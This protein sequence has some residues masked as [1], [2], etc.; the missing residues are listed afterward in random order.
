MDS[1]AEILKS[2]R[3]DRDYRNTHEYQAYGNKLAEELNDL[4][5]RSLYIKFAKTK[6]RNLLEKAREFVIAQ[7]H[8]HNKGPLFM[9]KLKEIETEKN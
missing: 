6:D 8:I 4:S 5:H 3:S 1:I 2:K 9:W 7:E